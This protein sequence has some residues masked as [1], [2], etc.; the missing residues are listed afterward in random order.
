MIIVDAKL[1]FQTWADLSSFRAVRFAQEYVRQ[2]L[3]YEFQYEL[4]LNSSHDD[5]NQGHFD[6]YPEDDARIVRYS[7][8]DEVVQELVR[9]DRIPVWIDISAFKHAKDF[10]VLRLICAGRFTNDTERLYYYDCGTGC[11]GV[12][13]PDLPPGSR[14]GYKFKIQKE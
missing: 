14:E 5:P 1:S 4:Y 13:S 7:T 9:N 11:F 10:T 12:K 2:N 8:L 6:L 3:A